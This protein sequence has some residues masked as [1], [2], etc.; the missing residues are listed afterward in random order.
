MVKRRTSTDPFAELNW[1]DLNRWAGGKIV[2]RGRGYQNDGAVKDLA[3]AP[4]GGLI[5]WVDGTRR[6][7]VHVERDSQGGLLSAC[8][9]PYEGACK[10]AVAVVLEYLQCLEKGT[11]VPLARKDDKRFDEFEIDSDEDDDEDDEFDREEEETPARGR[12]GG[13]AS[14]P[15]DM[16]R[17]ELVRL[18]RGMA[19]RHQ[20]VREE[21]EDRKAVSQGKTGTLVRSVRRKIREAAAEPGWRNRWD[22]YGDVADYSGI[23]SG[24]AAL[25]EAGCADAVLGLA[26]ELLEAATLQAEESCDEGDTGSDV[27][28]CAA[29]VAKAL[30]RSPR[31]IAEKILWTLRGQL[32]QIRIKRGDR[33]GE[34]SLRVDEFLRRPSQEACEECRKATRPGNLWPA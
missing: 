21:L 32:L 30:E 10:H 3:R 27:A 15:E 34:A 33:L 1:A 23:Q 11:P 31:P 8:T 24:L 9:C 17:E 18:V 29:V 26:E 12:G 6:Y 4:G 7:A 16:S 2:G 13:F 25:L 22:R 28:G 20:Q 5:A 19:E 14:F